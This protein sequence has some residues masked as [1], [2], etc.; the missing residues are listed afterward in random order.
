MTVV[1][2]IAI[3]MIG[4]KGREDT[5][6]GTIHWLGAS[7]QHYLQ[8]DSHS[9]SSGIFSS[10]FHVFTILWDEISVR[11]YVD[12]FLSHVRSILGEHQTELHNNFYFMFNVNIGGRMD[13]FN[14]AFWPG[15]PDSTTEFPQKMIIDYVRVYELE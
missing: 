2:E 6:W 1:G 3:D 4:G 5:I 15:E 11:W 7:N 12:G 14:R 8:S 13:S 10:K 9:L